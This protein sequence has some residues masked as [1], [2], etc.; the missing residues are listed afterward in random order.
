MIVYDIFGLLQE[1]SSASE[2]GSVPRRKRFARCDCAVNQR[3]TVKYRALSAV[4]AQPR[5]RKL[6]FHLY[7]HRTPP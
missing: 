2:G 6:P 5:R 3:W 1:V 7:P 4:N